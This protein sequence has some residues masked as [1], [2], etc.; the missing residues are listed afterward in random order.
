[1]FKVLSLRSWNTNADNLSEMMN[2]Y[3]EVLGGTVERTHTVGGVEVA[4]LR[5]GDTT[6]GLFDA[7]EGP[8]PGVPHHT[9][10]IEGPEDPGILV[11]ELESSGLRVDNV[12][13]HGD[14]P[15]YSIYIDDPSGNRI[16][17]SSDPV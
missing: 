1:M 14:G 7:S 3:Q 10:D 8:R 11:K 5:L 13:Q 2:F 4:R 15:G 12:R 16:E 17:L 9:F 6:I